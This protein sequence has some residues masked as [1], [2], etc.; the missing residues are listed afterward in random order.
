MSDAYIL[1]AIR[2]PF[3]RYGGGLSR[4]RPDDLAAHV[5]RTMLER[6]PGLEGEKIDDGTLLGLNWYVKGIDDKM[7]Q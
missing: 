6:T 7:P 4:V 2:T 1:D 5:V 3:G